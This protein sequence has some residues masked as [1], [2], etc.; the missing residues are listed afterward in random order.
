M[1][2]PS[3]TGQPRWAMAASKPAPTPRPRQAKLEGG[4]ARIAVAGVEEPDREVREDPAVDD[5]GRCAGLNRRELDRLEEVRDGHAH[6]HR[7][8]DL[9]LVRLDLRIA[10]VSPILRQ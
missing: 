7:I 9:E 6:P 10:S 3:F 5:R 4:P 2:M 8:G 1:S